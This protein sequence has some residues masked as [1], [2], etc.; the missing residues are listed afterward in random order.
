MKQEKA[1]KETKKQEEK[2]TQPDADISKKGDEIQDEL[3]KLDDMID[4]ALGEDEKDA[5][6]RAQEFV[7]GFKQKGGE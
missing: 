4:E 7:D 3:D 1:S 5:E 6:R 2:S